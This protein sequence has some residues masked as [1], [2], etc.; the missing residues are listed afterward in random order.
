MVITQGTSCERE[1]SRKVKAY[2]CTDSFQDTMLASTCMSLY[3][4]M[5]L[6]PNTVAFLPLL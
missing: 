2:C 4:F 6:K 5:F 3:L 1:G